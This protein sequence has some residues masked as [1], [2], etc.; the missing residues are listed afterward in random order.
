MGI[1]IDHVTVAGT[2]I[3]ALAGAFASAGLEADY[4]GMH[5][6]QAT[7]MSL[8]GFD[9]GT[10]IELFSVMRPGQPAP[11]WND[12]VIFDGGPCAWAIK[13]DDVSAEMARLESLGVP[14]E[15][16]F[17]VQRKRPD[18]VMIEWER[19]YVGEYG[20]GA[21]HPIIV[22]DRTPRELR[23][24]PSASVSGGSLE[25]VVRVV[26]GVEN[27][28]KAAEEFQRVYGLSAPRRIESDLLDGSLVQFDDAPIAL[29]EPRVERDW[30]AQRLEK[31]GPTPCA[32]LIGARDMNA[33][34]D[35]YRVAQTG[36]WDDVELDW[37]DLNSLGATRIGVVQV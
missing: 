27:N 9:D 32:F 13:V 25:G 20:A 30:L 36:R 23:S 21:M 34:R 26:L 8:L 16:P 12:H 18:E 35:Q 19:A 17:H 3:E 1:E 28:E 14:V 5:R 31:F 10:Y 7:H 15:G 24:I 6:S 33:V 11:R 29:V 37:L 4:G 22:K 2:R